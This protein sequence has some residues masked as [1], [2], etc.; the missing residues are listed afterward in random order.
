MNIRVAAESLTIMAVRQIRET[1]Q[2]SKRM[3]KPWQLSERPA[4]KPATA[5]I[6]IPEV[7]VKAIEISH[8]YSSLCSLSEA[9]KNMAGCPRLQ[10]NTTS[11]R[12][13]RSTKKS[14]N[15]SCAPA[16]NRAPTLSVIC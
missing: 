5:A 2:L 9:H 13:G 10:S 15:N 4:E 1:R 11:K 3:S 6:G 16:T 7:I 8:P 14:P 12:L